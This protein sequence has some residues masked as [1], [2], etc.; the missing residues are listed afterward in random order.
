MEIDLKRHL[1][2]EVYGL[3]IGLAIT[4]EFMG[5]ANIPI[6]LL[7]I[8]FFIGL[9]NTIYIGYYMIGL[10]YNFKAIPLILYGIGF[11]PMWGLLCVFC[12]PLFV[13]EGLIFLFRKNFTRYTL[14]FHT[15]Y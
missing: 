1:I 12:L 5:Y 8:C 4:T 15:T 14:Y 9:A 7:L 6:Q 11:V 10:E 2:F 13:L 3:I